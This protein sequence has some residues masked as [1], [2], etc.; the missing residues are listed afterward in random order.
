MASDSRMKTTLSLR[1]AALAVSVVVFSASAELIS[2]VIYYYQTGHL[3][4]T[5]RRTYQLIPETKSGGLTS[6]GLHPYFG[7]THK[8]GHPFDLP[9]HL[10]RRRSGD[11]SV[12]SDPSHPPSVATNNFGFVSPY[13]Y[14]FVKTRPDQFVI[15]ILGGSVGLWFCEVGA[16]RLIE[17]LQRHPFFRNKALISIC[18]SH[19]GY[20][21]PQQLL[22]L[23]YLL[24]IGQQFD[25]VINIDGF[26]EVAL[27]S[28]N[29]QHGSDV[30][31]PSFIH[32]GP[33]VNLVDQ[34]TLTPAKLQSL[35]A[36]SRFKERL[37]GLAN[38]INDTHLAS[39]N[40]VLERYYTMLSNR[41]RAELLTFGRLPSNS[42]ATSIIHVT[43][44]L[45]D[46][47]DA[48]LFRDIA[49]NWASSSS[50]MNEL[51]EARGTA[52]FHFLQPNQ[53]HTTRVFGATEADVALS[54]ESPFRSAVTRGYPALVEE[55]EARALKST[56]NF[57]D[58]I[59][60]FDDARAPMYMDNCCHY[61]LAG[62]ELLADF[63]ST[64]ILGSRGP[65]NRA[66]N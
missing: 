12:G 45:R 17:S 26:N 47:D 3:F 9:E 30:S 31:M 23:A 11:G 40:V 4:Y 18:L 33:L 19:E 2:L 52:Y 60:V 28:V 57:F 63:M 24:S 64:R 51:L 29:D 42:S 21:Q 61:T 54:S 10:R 41:Y 66:G 49:R 25:L 48:T 53:Y 36:I 58:A 34:S 27:S 50:L 8:P 20:K 59:H 7:P 38:R 56:L 37:N 43:P 55:S 46:R 39:V 35:A 62:N 65:W 1:L 44:R 5:F 13:D 15:G 6:V 16:P 32:L 22:V 14:P